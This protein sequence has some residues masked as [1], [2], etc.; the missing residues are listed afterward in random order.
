MNWL[1]DVL[2]NIQMA[3]NENTIPTEEFFIKMD[4][5]ANPRSMTKIRKIIEDYNIF[6]IENM[7]YIEDN[8]QIYD[9]IVEKTNDII[10]QIKK[11][12]LKNILTINRLIETS[13]ELEK[14]NNKNFT[15]KNNNRYTRKILNILYK[16]DT[17]KFLLNFL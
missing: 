5:K 4:G 8:E 2:D 3:S 10:F 12:K 11:M 17:D 15:K 7:K 6:V 1:Q 16:T 13:L 14:N 9:S